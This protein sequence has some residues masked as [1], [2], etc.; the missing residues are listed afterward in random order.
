MVLEPTLRSAG[1]VSWRP[2]AASMLLLLSACSGSPGAPGDAAP[3]DMARADLVLDAA[4]DGVAVPPLLGPN[5]AGYGEANCDDCHK[6]PEQ[7]HTADQPPLCAVCHG[8]NGACQPNAGKKGD[9]VRADACLS[10]HG[11]E[12]GFAA[13]ADCASCHLASA[14]TR[15]CEIAA[16]AG[17]PA[18]DLGMPQ[19]LGGAPPALSSALK[20]GCFGWPATP[21]SPSNKASWTT[22]LKPGDTAVELTLADTSGKPFTLSQ[23]L[24][25]RPVWIQF[26]S[27]T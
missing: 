1:A 11:A 17:P 24:V 10:C 2:L 13:K 9:H 20:Q 3:S 6:L 22:F 19:D 25:E 26:G 7:G 21:F 15:N 27:Y 5:H 14:G 23:L 16:D 12:H 4:F 18:P 8:G